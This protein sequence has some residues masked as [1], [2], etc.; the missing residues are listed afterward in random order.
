[1]MMVYPVSQFRSPGRFLFSGGSIMKKILIPI[2]LF[3]STQATFAAASCFPLPDIDLSY[4]WFTDVSGHGG[5][6]SM[7]VVPDGSGDS[8]DEVFRSDGTRV[9]GEIS[10][11]VLDAVG[12]GMAGVLPAEMT[13]GSD[14]VRLVFCD[15]FN[16]ARVATDT[17]GS[18]YFGGP[19][20]GGGTSE[21]PLRIAVC[22]GFLSSVGLPLQINSP[23]ITGDLK[24]DLSDVQLFASDFYGSYDYRSDF[25]YDGV[26][27]LSDVA[28]LAKHMGANCPGF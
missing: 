20:G 21:S 15:E 16:I 9:N 13:V 7:M 23:D 8:L 2:V 28:R 25:E 18:S 11:T 4:A 27:N 5:T 14:D 17:D 10:L 1:M 3:I 24:V 26:V 12:Q 19:F 22:Y 6:L